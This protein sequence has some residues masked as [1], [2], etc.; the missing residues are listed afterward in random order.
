MAIDDFVLFELSLEVGCNE[1]PPSHA[2]AS[3][4]SYGSERA[5][6]C[7]AHGGAK[8]LVEIDASHLCASL[9]T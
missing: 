1:I 5:E 2:H 8:S 9:Y 3:R 6:R 4:V 7:G